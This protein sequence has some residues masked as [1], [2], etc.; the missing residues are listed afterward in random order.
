MNPIPSSPELSGRTDAFEDFSFHRNPVPGTTL[1]PGR[2]HEIS[3]PTRIA[4]RNSGPLPDDIE[5]VSEIERL[6]DQSLASQEYA[7]IF[8]GGGKFEVVSALEAQLWREERLSTKY[9]LG[10]RN[11]FVDEKPISSAAIV[12]G[13]IEP[14]F[15]SKLSSTSRVKASRAVLTSFANGEIMPNLSS[16]MMWKDVFLIYQ[17]DGITND[18]LIELMLQVDAVRRSG[19]SRITI[20]AP[21]FPYQRSDKRVQDGSPVSAAAIT[22]ILESQGV[23]H[24]VCFDLHS[25]Q[26]EGFSEV[27]ISNLSVLPMIARQV[28]AKFPDADFVVALPDEGMGKRLKDDRTRSLICEILGKSTTFLQ[29]SKDRVEVNEVNSIHMRNGRIDLSGKTVLILDDMIDTGHTM[30]MAARA[31]LKVGAKNILAGATHG[32]FSG[33][34]IESFRGDREIVNGQAIRP[35][36]EIFISDSVP[37]RRAKGDLIQIVSIAEPLGDIIKSLA[38]KDGRS[39][40]DIMLTHSGSNVL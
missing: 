30:R 15:F 29:M 35:I 18:P 8:I 26:A 1:Q 32:I 5:S 33:D 12:G 9:G 6:L 40:A 23:D 4:L 28:S 16:G 21:S 36:S 31:L 19:A 13:A 20:V 2:C 38:T 25:G 34:A 7:H 14:T 17:P 27:P 3:K 39:L 22:R 10:D 11:L 24:F 37:L